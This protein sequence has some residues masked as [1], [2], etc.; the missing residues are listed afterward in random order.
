MTEAE[1]ATHLAFIQQTAGAQSIVTAEGVV[2]PSET[3]AR[4]GADLHDK[5]VV[6][7]GAGWLA[8]NRL[9]QSGPMPT[10]NGDVVVLHQHQLFRVWVVTADGSQEPD[11]NV[12]P[13]DVWS[14]AE[15]MTAA[16]NWRAE[17][18]GRMFLLQNNGSGSCGKN[19]DSPHRAMILLSDRHSLRQ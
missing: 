9:T 19:S 11:P 1:M 6:Q 14:R 13:T 12:A 18:N 7:I 17:T 16:T 5:D 3:A 15:A 2:Y 10:L 8:K 4:N